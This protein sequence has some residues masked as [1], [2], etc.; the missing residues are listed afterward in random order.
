MLKQNNRRR[1]PGL[2]TVLIALLALV[3]A[4]FIVFVCVFRTTG[5]EISSTDKKMIDTDRAPV[6]IDF[7]KCMT[8]KDDMLTNINMHN[9]NKYMSMQMVIKL[10]PNAS[11]E[12]SY[13]SPVIK[14]GKVLVS[15]RF[16]GEMNR[17]L[18]IG[19]TA[20]YAFVRVFDIDDI[21]VSESSFVFTLNKIR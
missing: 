3:L 15:D 11:D 18:D 4:L 10:T 21:Q 8:V 6:S 13:V 12:E 20:A 7:S 2:K 19:T 9:P 5:P 17:K 1:L 16:P 14:P